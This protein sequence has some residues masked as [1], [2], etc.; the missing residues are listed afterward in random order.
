[1]LTSSKL[2]ILQKAHLMRFG[3]NKPL[4][5]YHAVCLSLIAPHGSTDMWV[6]P[7]QKYALNYGSS[8]ALFLFQP[9][10]IKFFF[11]FLYSIYHLMHDISA[12]APVQLAYSAGLHLSWVCFPEWALTYLAWIHT[13][14]HYA[15]VIPLLTKLQLF[16]LAMTHIFVYFLIRKYETNDLSF[17]GTWIPL[18]IGHIMTNA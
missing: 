12:I 5:T 11:L 4:S 10:R 8:C 18:V 7:I 17:G 2:P 9:I 13:P 6:H 3:H 16:S 1:M 15:R 14:L